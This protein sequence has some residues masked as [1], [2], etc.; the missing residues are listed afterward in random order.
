MITLNIFPLGLGA[1]GGGEWSGLCQE[2]PL[3]L[4]NLPIHTR[5]KPKNAW[6]NSWFATL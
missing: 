4:W 1:G 5:C 2:V 3:D 6:A